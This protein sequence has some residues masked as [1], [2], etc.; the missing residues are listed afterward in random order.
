[1][2]EL[3]RP[4]L[5]TREAAKLLHLRPETL[6]RWHESGKLRGFRISSR[7]LR[8]DPDELDDFLERSRGEADHDAAQAARKRGTMSEERTETTRLSDDGTRL[9]IVTRWLDRQVSPPRWRSKNRTR[10]LN[11]GEIEYFR[12]LEAIREEA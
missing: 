6:L 11:A 5:T 2:S 3:R 1:V 8:F 10:K 7:A 12:Q 4:L 9:V